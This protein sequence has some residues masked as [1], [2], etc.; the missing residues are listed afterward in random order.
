MNQ[1]PPKVVD[2]HPAEWESEKHSP[3]VTM[4]WDGIGALI[5]GGC[6]LLYKIIFG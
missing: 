5:I 3:K 2:L 6:V 1:D 4:F